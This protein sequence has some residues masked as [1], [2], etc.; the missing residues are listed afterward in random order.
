MHFPDTPDPRVDTALRD[1]AHRP[2]WLD[3]V[4]RPEA[5]DPLTGRARTA[6]LVVGAGFTGLWTAIL[7]KQRDPLR[8]VL[9]LDAGP[10]AGQAS[11]RNGGFVHASLTH[12]AANG[13]AHFPEDM[14]LLTRLGDENLIAIRAFVEDRGIACDWRDAGELE[15]AFAAHQAQAMRA[16]DDPRLTWLT[17]EA[18][19]ER[20]AL[21]GA[22]GATYEREVSLVHPA[23]LAW[24]LRDAALTAGVRIHEHTQALALR[25]DGGTVHVDTPHG[26]IEADRVVLATNAFPSLLPAVRRRIVPV[27][28]YV[29]VTEPLSDAQWRDVGWRG[30]EGIKG[31][32]NRFHYARRTPDGRILWGGYDAVY[33][34]NNGIG[35]DFEHD[36]ASYRRLA[37]HFLRVFPQLEGIR[38]THAW[39]GAIDTCTRFTPFWTSAC[40]GR[41]VA[42]A[43]FTGLG[44]GSSRFAADVALDRVDGVRSA[45]GSTRMARST[46]V[47][48]PPEPARSAVIGLT[49]WA[50]ARQDRRSGQRNAWLRLLDRFGVGFDS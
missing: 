15:V 12:G 40:A 13:R 21:T 14:P 5:L 50:L 34:A 22:H 48:F 43:G 36:V 20:I 26:A 3:D 8:E 25:T 29:L 16:G 7:A 1:A 39:G 2:F 32:G 42:V 4:A 27:Y 19:Q 11:G 45:A 38:F 44:V 46:P 24:G 23:R 47:P 33:H 18:L 9:V 41:V 6:L 31:A 35:P 28:D 30:F 10:V 49:Q 37:D 17:P